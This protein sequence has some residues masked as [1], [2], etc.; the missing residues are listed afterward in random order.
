MCVGQ[1]VSFTGVASRHAGCLQL[2]QVLPCPAL[3]ARALT[4]APALLLLEVWGLGAALVV[5]VVIPACRAGADT[6]GSRGAMQQHQMCL[7]S[8]QCRSS[9]AQKAAAAAV[10]IRGPPHYPHSLSGCSK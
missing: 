8:W 2:P 3:V 1:R 6:G 4:L 10:A 5:A 9:T 7:Q